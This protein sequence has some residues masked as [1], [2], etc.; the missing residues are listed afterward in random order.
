MDANQ[1][2]YQYI[3]LLQQLSPE[4]RQAFLLQAEERV[5]SESQIIIEEG[6]PGLEFFVLLEGTVEI[7]KM[8]VDPS[9]LKRK[10]LIGIRQA[11]DYF[12]EIA[13]LEEVPRSARV[14]AC[15]AVRTLCINKQ[16][17]HYFLDNNPH[18]YIEFFRALSYRLRHSNQQMIEQL[19]TKT[20][21]LAEVNATLEKKVADRTAR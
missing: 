10:H 11:G 17:F 7:S 5:F 18:L 21:K 12:G 4:D 9:G 1:D 13:L 2:P 16:Q 14:T 15:T 8:G 19:E 3:S 6:T 20:Q